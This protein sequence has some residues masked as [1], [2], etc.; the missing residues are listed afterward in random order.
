MPKPMARIGM[1]MMRARLGKLVLMKYRQTLLRVRVMMMPIHIPIQN[2]PAFGKYPRMYPTK[3][4][5]MIVRT[6]TRLMV[7]LGIPLTN[8]KKD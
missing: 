8:I 3:K 2:R 4:E 1:R 5:V 7:A 6:S